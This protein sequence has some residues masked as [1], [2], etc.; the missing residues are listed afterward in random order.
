MRC[1]FGYGLDHVGS[2]QLRDSCD[3]NAIMTAEAD[4]QRRIDRLQGCPVLTSWQPG[5]S[6]VTPSPIRV[7]VRGGDEGEGRG[8]NRDVHQKVAPESAGGFQRVHL[9]KKAAA[10]RCAALMSTRILQSSDHAG[11]QLGLFRP[12]QVAA[13]R[14]RRRTTPLSILT[15]R[16]AWPGLQVSALSTQHSARSTQHSQHW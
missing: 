10:Q 8:S 2:R 12:G 5:L 4:G 3:T 16:Q 11:W 7:N 6:T 13:P 9:L 14:L 15:L 1:T